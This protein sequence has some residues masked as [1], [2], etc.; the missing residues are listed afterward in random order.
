[1]DTILPTRMHS[2]ALSSARLWIEA[3]SYSINI[4]IF[5]I[6]SVFSPTADKV[7]EMGKVYNVEEGWGGREWLLWLYTG[8][9]AKC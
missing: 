4:N 8:D 5:F 2:I 7:K 9:M 3:L 1:M 6:P